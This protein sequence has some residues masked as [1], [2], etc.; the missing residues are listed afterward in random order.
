[1]LPKIFVDSEIFWQG[2]HAEL[3]EARTEVVG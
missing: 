1:M 2:R 3:A